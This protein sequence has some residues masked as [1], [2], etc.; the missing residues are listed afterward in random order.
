[1][2]TYLQSWETLYS[3]HI[4]G[5]GIRKFPP[6]IRCIKPDA[7]KINYL[8][9]YHSG[10]ITKMRAC[11]CRHRGSNRIPDVRVMWKRWE[12]GKTG[13]QQD[14]RD[15]KRKKMLSLARFVFNRL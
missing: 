13:E 12:E 14:I 8:M 1:M 3:G 7:S 10:S 15:H 9:S 4:S 6:E 11:V 2:P 5:K